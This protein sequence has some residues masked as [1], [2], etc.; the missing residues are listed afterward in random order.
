M[1]EKLQDLK[2]GGQKQRGC[3]PFRSQRVGCPITGKGF[4]SLVA[5]GGLRREGDFATTSQDF[6]HYCGY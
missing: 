3:Y 5:E 1:P 6:T 2:K 4:G